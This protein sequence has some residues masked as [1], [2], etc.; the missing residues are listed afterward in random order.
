M[1]PF[2]K[3]CYVLVLSPYDVY[4]DR[5]WILWE[6]LQAMK[7][8]KL[9]INEHVKPLLLKTGTNPTFE[10]VQV[11]LSG[12]KALIESE[13]AEMFE[14]IK[15]LYFERSD[16]ALIPVKEL[17]KKDWKEKALEDPYIP[18]VAE[19]IAAEPEQ[20]LGPQ[21]PIRHTLPLASRCGPS[22]DPC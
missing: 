14:K 12:A 19:V 16:Y 13:K 4:K 17:S 6:C 8:R 3:R 20:L 15:D 21:C 1:V 11:M 10:Q 22:T 9:I 2:I 18:R 5:F 7:N